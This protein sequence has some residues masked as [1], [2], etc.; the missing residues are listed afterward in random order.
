MVFVYL[1]NTYLVHARQPEFVEDRHEGEASKRNASK[2]AYHGHEP[3][4]SIGVDF[5]RGAY[6]RNEST[7]D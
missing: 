3:L 2:E 4:W 5:S 6:W 7:E 1:Y